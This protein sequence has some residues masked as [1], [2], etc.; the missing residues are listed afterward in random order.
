V[1]DPVKRPIA[2]RRETRIRET[3]RRILAA[4]HE[5]FVA[6]GWAGTTL[7]DVAAAADVAERTV[8]VRF[9][10]K[11][12]LLNRVIG[13]AIAGDADPIPVRDRPWYRTALTAPT[14]EGRIDAY[15]AGASALM[16]RAAPVI[17]VALSAM[18][19]DSAIAD[20]ARAG[21]AGTR[22]DV[23]RLWQRA[24]NDGLF[25]DHVDVTWFIET[26]S[27]IL[28]ADVYLLGVEVQSWTPRKYEN[29]LRTTIRR[30]LALNELVDA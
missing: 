16:S 22:E 26:V 10:T 20:S 18:G 6:D 24:H 29:W 2:D 11:G 27:V 9:G 17:A 3:E 4:A 30:L 28:Q 12:A 5:L 7:R 13:A 8:Y 21:H 25:P 23:K 19:D 14:L 1:P 15:A